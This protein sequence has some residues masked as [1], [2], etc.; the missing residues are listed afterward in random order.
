MKSEQIIMVVPRE[1]LFENN[2]HYFEGFRHAD[3]KDFETNILQN[4][5][6]MKRG[7][8][9][10]DPNHKQPIAYCLI[11]NPQQKKVFAFQR[12][13]KDE[14]Y[15]EKRLQ[16][17]HSW[18]VGGH[19]EQFDTA[20]GNPIYNSMLREIEEEI[21][22]NGSMEPK[23]LGYIN[24]DQD[25]VSKVHF[26]VLYLIETDAVDVRPRDNEMAAGFR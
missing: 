21:E 9:E 26:G 1:D 8:A 16:G 19:I 23:V 25:D 12:G 3:V 22:C 20:E 24:S 14:H 5:I 10:E 2:E 13:L 15:G 7:I 18:G 17:K 6:W 11:V 4:H